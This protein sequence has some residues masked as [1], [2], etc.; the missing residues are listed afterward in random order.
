MF[1]QVVGMVVL[2]LFGHAI[3][4]VGASAFLGPSGIIGTDALAWH[5]CFCCSVRV[6]AIQV[7]RFVF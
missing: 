2:A 6:F 4:S 7:T 1:S 3:E 5:I